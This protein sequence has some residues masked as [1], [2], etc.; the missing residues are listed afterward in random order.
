[1]ALPAAARTSGLLDATN[2]GVELLQRQPREKRNLR[3]ID[4]RAPKTASRLARRR[5]QRNDAIDAAFFRNIT[6]YCDNYLNFDWYESLLNLK[7]DL[8][9]GDIT[10]AYSMLADRTIKEISN[11]VPSC[12]HHPSPA[13]PGERLWSQLCM[14]WR[15]GRIAT[16]S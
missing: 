5:A 4:I 16:R 11:A 1:M 7:G 8:L 13:R 14:E 15:N 12:P 2:Q 3:L 10:E 6:S 9:T